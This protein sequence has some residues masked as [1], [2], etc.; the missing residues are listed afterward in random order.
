MIEVKYLELI[1]IT[2]NIC[3]DPKKVQAIIDWKSPTTVKDMQAFL[4][5]AEF[6]QQFIAR[7]SRMT[8]PLTKMIKSNHMTTRSGKS[9]VKYNPFQ[10]TKDCKKAFQDLKQIFITASILAY[11]NFKLKTQIKTNF[12]NFVTADML[13]QMYHGVLRAVAY[14]LKKLTLAE[15]NYMIYNKNS[16]QQSRVLKYGIQNQLALQTK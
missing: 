3:I 8:K 11:Y 2:E 7:F 13:L 15:C 9:K 1:V 10:W 16:L 12:S 6:Y 4:K 5:F 14:F